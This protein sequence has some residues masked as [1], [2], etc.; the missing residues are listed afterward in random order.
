MHRLVFP[1]SKAGAHPQVCTDAKRPDQQPD[2]RQQDPANR[3]RIYQQGIA[4]IPAEDSAIDATSSE[5]SLTR[6][7]A[8]SGK[9]TGK[10]VE[11]R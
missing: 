5:V 4:G 2:F 11:V 8:D 6:L 3:Y 9:Y 10:E 7:Y 1:F